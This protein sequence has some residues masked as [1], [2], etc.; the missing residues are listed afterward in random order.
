MT[1]RIEKNGPVWTVIHSRF[2]EARN[3]M[4]PDSAQALCDAFLEYEADPEARV[5]VLWGEGGAFCAG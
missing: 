2:E 5:A 3:G 1:V 4:D